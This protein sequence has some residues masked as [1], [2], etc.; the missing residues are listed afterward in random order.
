MQIIITSL[1]IMKIMG[2]TPSR[3]VENVVNTVKMQYKVIITPTS[4]RI[5]LNLVCMIGVCNLRP[6]RV[7]RMDLLKRFHIRMTK[8][9]KPCNARRIIYT[10]LISS[11][12][13]ISVRYSMRVQ[14][15]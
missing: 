3:A 12:K 8:G 11:Y 9:K 10:M 4:D 13:L 7:L 2:S 15:K 14:P 1:V 5:H 6:M